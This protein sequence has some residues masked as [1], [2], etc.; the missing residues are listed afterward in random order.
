M[1]LTTRAREGL[2]IKLQINGNITTKLIG[3]LTYGAWINCSNQQVIPQAYQAL[4]QFK[5]EVAENWHQPRVQ[6]WLLGKYH[7]E[8]MW[9]CG[10]TYGEAHDCRS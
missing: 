3:G 8:R 4:N 9:S 2:Q 6:D 5:Y 10:R 1:S 7:F